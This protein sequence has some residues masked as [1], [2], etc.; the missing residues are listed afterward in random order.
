LIHAV[1]LWDEFFTRYNQILEAQFNSV[2]DQMPEDFQYTSQEAQDEVRHL[3]LNRVQNW[4]K[5]PYPP[6]QNRTPEDLID[7]LGKLDEIMEVV[8][9]A[10]LRCDDDIPDYLKIRLGTFGGAAVTALTDLVLKA[11][12]EG[13][14]HSEQE[15]SLEMQLS[16]GALKLLGEWGIDQDQEDILNK[17]CATATPHEWIADAV[18][19]YLTRLDKQSVELVT[20]ILNQTCESDNDFKVPHEYLMIALTMIGTAE[21]NDV[22]FTC[23]RGCFRKMDHK[24]IGAICLGDY[25]D[26]RGIRVLKGYLD[27]HTDTTDRQTFYE[28]LSSIRRLGGDIRDIQDPFRDFSPPVMNQ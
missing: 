10:F 12:W 18:K 23:L 22:I 6:W 9:L 25:G 13:D 8:K 26:P 14:Y 20:E 3:V 7:E 24:V 28:I 2:M 1:E 4:Y 21:K 19:T 5:Q 15:P 11:D 16:F 17:F 27:R